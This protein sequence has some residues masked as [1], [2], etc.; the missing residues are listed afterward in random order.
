MLASR[1]RVYCLFVASL[2]ACEGQS[3][4]ASSSDQVWK[5][6]QANFRVETVAKGLENPWSLAFLPDG[7]MLITERPGRL[8][9][10]DASGEYSEPLAGLPNVAASGQGGLL[11]VVLDPDFAGNRTI[12]LSYSASG[13]GSYSTNVASARLVNDRLSDVRVIFEAGIDASGGRHFGSRLAFDET[14][15]LLITHGD[16]GDRDL[17]QK[18]GSYAGK[19]IRIDRYGRVPS[20]NPFA[21]GTETL[22]TVFS[23]GHRNPQGLAIHPQTGDIWAHEHGPRGGDEVN[24]LHAGANYGWPLASHGAEYISGRPVSDD[25]SLPG[26]VDPVHVW[27]PSIAPSGM[28]FYTGDVFEAWQGDLFVGA[29]AGQSLVRLEIENSRVVGEERLLEGEY[30]RIRDVRQGPDGSI[31]LLIDDDDGSIL[32]L[33]GD[34]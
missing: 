5:S 20:D 32:R 34:D 13:P 8:R 28:A 22:P 7:R 23:L 33:T 15:N 19:V 1:W 24:I 4:S 3:G 30:G 17:A 9:L 6:E 2:T 16:R 29:L 31:Y 25:R 10:V 18:P 26:M 12:Y 27:I 14:G 21:D 11:D